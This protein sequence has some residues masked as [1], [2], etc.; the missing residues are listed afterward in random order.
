MPVQPTQTTRP[1]TFDARTGTVYGLATAAWY[2]VPDLVERRGTRALLKTAC[3]V[4]GLAVLL[5]TAE[6]RQAIDGVRKV[7]DAVRDAGSIPDAVGVSGLSDGIADDS[8]PSG[9]GA[10]DGTA[11]DLTPVQI[12]T[13]AKI[14]IAAGA[15]VL[16]GAT[17]ALAVVG[18]KAAYRWGERMRARGVRAPHLRVGLVLGAASALLG[19]VNP[20]PTEDD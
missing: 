1:W 5:R 13:A 20:P 11:A 15:I 12:A 14:T 6:G 18:E 10:P 17:T 7:R 3:G 2:T 4:A 8:A 16:V 19:G 9:P